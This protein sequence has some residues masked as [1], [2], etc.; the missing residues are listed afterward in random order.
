MLIKI[1][2]FILI[3]CAISLAI[4]LILIFSQ[5]SQD[6]TGQSSLDFSRQSGRGA[7]PAPLLAY[8]TDDGDTLGFRRY[9]TNRAN[10]PLLVLVH[11]SGWHGLAFDALAQ[12]IAKADLAT[13]IVPD[14]RGHGP[15]PI[16]R[17]DVDYIGQFETDL[18]S[19]IKQEAKA[20]QAV[21]MGGHSSG[22]GLVIRY[23][24]GLFGDDL[25]GAILLA[26]FLKYNA[27]TMRQNAGGWA[28]TKTRRIIGLTML[29]AVGITALNHL[30]VIDFA[31]PQQIIDG[32]LG[33]TATRAYSYRLNVSYAPRSDYLADIAKLPPFRLIAGRS[34]EAFD[35]QAYEPTLSAVNPNGDYILLDD[36]SHLDVMYVD[37][38]FQAVQDYLNAL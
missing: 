12:R 16:R 5:T 22:G 31:F 38:T 11:G 28:E 18:H 3:S 32:P 17:G 33:H 36:V 19:L 26:P 14:L 20:G 21:V 2:S 27:P 37:E 9:T 34:D 6:R 1:I 35:A 13:V 4:A 10:A 29:N 30:K 23:A 24:N 15:N 25:D 8:K 7:D